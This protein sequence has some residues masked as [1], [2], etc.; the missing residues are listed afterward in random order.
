MKL[1]GENIHIISKSVR[2]ALLNRDEAFILDLIKKQSKME[3]IDLNVGPANSG[4]D[5]I[6]AWL[7]S[8]VEEN[9]DLKIS[10]DTANA[11]EMRK[12]LEACR[13]V[14]KS[15][16]NSAS[17]DDERLE[18]MTNL[19]AEFN[20]NLIALTLSSKTGIP[21]T[22]D[23]RV[24]LALDMYETCMTKGI[25]N[26]RIFFDPLILPVSVDQSQAAET[27]NTIT[28]IKE[29]FEPACN[30]VIGLSNISNGS[31]K[32]LRPL[33]NKVYLSLAMGAGLDAAIIDAKDEALIRM[34]NMLE[35]NTPTS[36]SDKLLLDLTSVTRDFMDIDDI[37][38]D[39]SD[40][41][42]NDIY[43]AALI[44]LNK[45]VYSHSFTQV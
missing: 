10:F 11:K 4:L 16:I 37:S 19:A 3:Y 23:G 29:S 24:E 40:K 43:K 44:L 33:I 17:D 25:S 27:L 1:I 35:N 41:E 26:E 32:E 45:E 20:T 8:L 39:K 28:I 42:S 30:T 5:G 9:S 7:A 34:V 2:T 31:P 14:S 13:N 6:L 15:V 38:Y 12:G 36:K 18:A 21:Q 22:A